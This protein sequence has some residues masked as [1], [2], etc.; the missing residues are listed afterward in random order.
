MKWFDRLKTWISTLSTRQLL[1]AVAISL[2]ITVALGWLILRPQTSETVAPV[3]TPDAASSAAPSVTPGSG[4]IIR[5]IVTDDPREYASTLIQSLCTWDAATTTRTELEENAAAWTDPAGGERPYPFLRNNSPQAL[6]KDWQAIKQQAILRL[7][8]CFV[9]TESNWWS[10]EQNGMVQTAT[11]IETKLN[12]EHEMWGT[13]QLNDDDLEI[14]DINTGES[15]D[16]N[17]VTVVVEVRQRP[18]AA[19]TDPEL[20]DEVDT[21]PNSG[22]RTV[23]FSLSVICHGPTD[24]DPPEPICQWQG[25][26]FKDYE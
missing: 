6:Q 11:V 9:P 15:Y 26:T 16:R 1:T 23:S 17:I 5:P 21:A 3:S 25:G 20:A 13:S 2:V 12:D 22:V 24:A 19:E 8:D 4:D 10:Y 14:T 7:D 18:A